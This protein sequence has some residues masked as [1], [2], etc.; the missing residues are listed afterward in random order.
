VK[1]SDKNYLNF[2]I[3]DYV[4]TN[5]RIIFIDKKTNL[6]RDYPSSICLIEEVKNET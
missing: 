1:L 6:R 3:D 4:N 5:S 2:T